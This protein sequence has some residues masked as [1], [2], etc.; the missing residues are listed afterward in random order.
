[1]VLDPRGPAP[2][3]GRDSYGD[4]Q[5]VSPFGLE[6]ATEAISAVLDQSQN[7]S[8]EQYALPSD[9]HCSFTLV[10]M[11][12]RSAVFGRIDLGGRNQAGSQ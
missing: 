12:V 7:R 4:T 2:L 6:Q 11:R 1:M 8:N 10:E 5:T 3:G 9:R